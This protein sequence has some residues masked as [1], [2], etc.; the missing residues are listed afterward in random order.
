MERDQKETKSPATMIQKSPSNNNILLT[1]PVEN[2]IDFWCDKDSEDDN[3]VTE[4]EKKNS[5]REEGK[6]SVVPGNTNLAEERINQQLYQGPKPSEGAFSEGEKE[7]LIEESATRFIIGGTAKLRKF[8]DVVEF[9]YPLGP[10]IVRDRR[11]FVRI[12]VSRIPAVALVD[13]GA[14]RTYVG[15]KFADRFGDR[16]AET[17]D[18]MRELLH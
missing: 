16:V 13:S 15:P 8:R 18:L 3:E 5:S 10:E 4:A 1:K 12:E 17:G 7:F 9:C 2:L 11:F 6:D 14:S